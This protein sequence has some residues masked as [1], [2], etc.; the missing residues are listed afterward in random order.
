M[1]RLLKNILLLVLFTF[2][3]NLSSSAQT[4]KVKD[5]TN[6][7]I[8]TLQLKYNFNHTQRG[9][10]FLDDLAEKEIIF[11]KELNRYIILEKIGEFYTSTP[12]FLTQKE[13]QQYRLKRDMLEYFK[14]KV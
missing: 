8:D 7:K 9:D 1:I 3:V 13:Y 11:D 10:L 5:S 4:K 12:I 2:L 14:N 6:L